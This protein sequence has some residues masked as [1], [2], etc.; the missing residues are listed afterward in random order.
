MRVDG[1]ISCIEMI[2]RTKDKMA[3]S[4]LEEVSNPQVHEEKQKIRKQFFLSDGEIILESEHDFFI[5]ILC[6]TLCINRLISIGYRVSHDGKSGYLYLTSSY[7]LFDC[8]F[9]SGADSEYQVAIPLTNIV[10]IK[11][12]SVYYALVIT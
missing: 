3:Q 9:S 4:F 7:V 12:V 5:F 8:Y 11:R 2:H 10:D 1:S 6:V